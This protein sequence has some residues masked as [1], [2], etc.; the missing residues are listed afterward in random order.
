[1]S[2]VGIAVRGGTWPGSPSVKRAVQNALVATT[3]DLPMLATL[4]GFHGLPK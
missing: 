3:M 2:I 1:L 4:T